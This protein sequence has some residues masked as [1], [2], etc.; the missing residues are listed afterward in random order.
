MIGLSSNGEQRVSASEISGR[1]QIKYYYF[2][3][4][5]MVIASMRL[6]L[7]P[8]CNFCKIRKRTNSH[9]FIQR[10]SKCS[11]G[12]KLLFSQRYKINHCTLI[13]CCTSEN[14]NCASS[15]RVKSGCRSLR[16]GLRLKSLPHVEKRFGIFPFSV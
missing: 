2:C 7:R 10:S 9:Q 15:V 3:S 1:A 12:N 8:K 4:S 13:H 5:H 14:C 11:S 6:S 16:G